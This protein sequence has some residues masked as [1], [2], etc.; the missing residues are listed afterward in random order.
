MASGGDGGRGD[1]TSK[2]QALFGMIDTNNDGA[3]S[4]AEII[5]AIRKASKTGDNPQLLAQVSLA[6]RPPR[7][8]TRLHLHAY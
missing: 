1:G 7:P 6:S 2:A 5:K 8:R 4:R 3:L